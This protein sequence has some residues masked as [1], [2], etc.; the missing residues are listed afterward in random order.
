MWLKLLFSVFI[1]TLLGLVPP[2]IGVY[3]LLLWLGL[4]SFSIPN[5]SSLFRL[6]F[7]APSPKLLAIYGIPFALFFAG[8]EVLIFAWLKTII[9]DLMHSL[10]KMAASEMAWSFIAAL[11]IAPLVEEFL[12]RGLLPRGLERRFSFTKAMWISSLIYGILNLDFIGTTIFALCLSLLTRECASLLPAIIIHWWKNL[13]SLC[14]LVLDKRNI[15]DILFGYSFPVGL[16]YALVV[17]G[18]PFVFYFL[19]KYWPS[20]KYDMQT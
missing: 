1:L 10:E 11:T 6:S 12:F 2:D 8:M 5:A 15:H 14:F 13:F 16:A 17:A 20:S 4:K 19:W 7:T 9:P 18:A 3:S